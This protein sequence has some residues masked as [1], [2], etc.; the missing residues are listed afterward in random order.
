V[1]HL[2]RILKGKTAAGQAPLQ[3][4]AV[5]TNAE[6]G[7]C[8]SGGRMLALPSDMVEE[9]LDK[10]RDRECALSLHQ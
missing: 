8:G 9:D 4:R 7:Q 5:K 1:D 3:F 10:V 6:A 2:L